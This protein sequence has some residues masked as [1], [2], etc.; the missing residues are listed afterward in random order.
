[1]LIARNSDWLMALFTPLVIGANNIK[2]CY[3][4]FDRHSKIAL[5]RSLNFV[6]FKD[7]CFFPQF[8]CTYGHECVK[9]QKANS[10]SAIITLLIVYVF[11][12][13]FSYSLDSI[14][15]YN[16]NFLAVELRT[17]CAVNAELRLVSI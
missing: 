10:P 2:I 14:G 3:W 12:F 5:N 17:F 16:G 15:G 13:L 8:L 1:M 9:I 6:L 4:F 7:P 11:L